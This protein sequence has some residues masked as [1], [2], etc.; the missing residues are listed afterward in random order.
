MISGPSPSRTARSNPRRP[1]RP[2]VID[3]GLLLLTV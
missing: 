1:G 2:L 3:V